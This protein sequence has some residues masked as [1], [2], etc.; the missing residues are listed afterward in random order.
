MP[1]T[2]S[3]GKPLTPYDPEAN[4]ILR[5]MENQGILS[6]SNVGNRGYIAGLQPP[7]IVGANNHVPIENQLGDALRV[8]PPAAQDL[9][10]IIE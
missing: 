10:I 7:M 5:R 4:H 1:S 2:Q 9:R 3:Q 6:N 8:Q